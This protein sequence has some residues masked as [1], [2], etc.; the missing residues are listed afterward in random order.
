MTFPMQKM[1]VFICL[2]LIKLTIVAQDLKKD[3]LQMSGF[4]RFLYDQNLY[5]FAAQEYERLTYLYPLDKHHL[6]MLLKSYRKL[7]QYDK[8]EQKG[9]TLSLDDD[10][11]LKE[12]LLSLALNEQADVAELIYSQH[13]NVLSS[14]DARRLELDFKVMKQDWSAADQLYH[15]FGIQDAGYYA[16]I[17][18]GIAQKYKSPWKAGLLSGILP[19]SGRLYAKDTKDGIIS[20]IFIATTTYQAYRRFSKGGIKSAG[21]WIYGGFA[22]GFY[23]ANIYGSVNA[24]KKYN[25]QQKAKLHAEGKNHIDLYY[26]N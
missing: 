19:G 24:A 20:F 8:I 6:I 21:G 7:N 5:E 14:S 9:S 1:L 17:R 4:A 3:S 2:M 16:L 13:P 23:I 26:G 25:K 12:Y 11:I 10:Q 18:K 22:T 15:K